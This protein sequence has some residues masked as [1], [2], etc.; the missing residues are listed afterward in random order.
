A[1]ARHTA[2]TPDQHI[3]EDAEST[4][5]IE[6]LEDVADIGAQSAHVGIETAGG[7]DATAQYSNRTG[8]VAVSACESRQ[9]TQERGLSGAGCA[10]ER[11]HL[12]SEE[13][14]SELQSRENL[15]CRLLLEKKKT[16]NTPHHTLT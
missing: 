10:D 3:A 8:R 1:P 2:Q 14:T 9:M 16:N 11:N 15:V 5:Q 12:R 7:L 6:L 4:D 13:H